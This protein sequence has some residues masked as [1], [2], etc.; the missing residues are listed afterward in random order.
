MSS[1]NGKRWSLILHGGA[2]EIAP[3]KQA[4]NRSGCSAALR[5]GAKILA[6]GGS[7][8]DAVEAVVRALEDDPTFNAGYGSVLNADGKVEMDAGVMDGRTLQVG[9]VGAIEGVRNPV[10]V[11]RRMLPELPVLLVAA[12]ARRFA[13]EHGIEL[14]D[15]DALIYRQSSSSQ[16][17]S[18]ESATSRHDTVGCV[19]R[20]SNG[21]I[22]A[23]TSTGGLTGKHPGR[24]GD[25]PLIGSGM[26]ADDSRGGVSFSGDGESIVRTMLA[27]RVMQS[28]EHV[29]AQGAI[30]RALA[31]LPLVGGEGGGIVIDREGRIG[32]AHSSSH[33]AIAYLTSEHAA[34]CVW[35]SK[36]EEAEARS[37]HG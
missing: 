33:F 28:L 18:G 11:A 34:E 10:S 16:Q 17:P 29:D 32:W 27:A 12:G 20:D 36:Q 31:A 23:G 13:A 1:L 8:L 3:A 7:A 26:Y 30:D 37:R 6:G 22:A 19:A 9:A 5:R 14:C 35:L 2:K 24:I 4:A 25:S 15:P 21:N